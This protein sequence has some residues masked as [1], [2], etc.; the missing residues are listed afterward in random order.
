[1][2]RVVEE[3]FESIVSFL[4]VFIRFW[5]YNAGNQETP[6]VPLIGWSLFRKM[7]EV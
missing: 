3:K 6:L 1:M 4:G 5:Y 7:Y 2:T